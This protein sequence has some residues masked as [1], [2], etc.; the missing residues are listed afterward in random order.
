MLVPEKGEIEI[1]GPL[2]MQTLSP[3]EVQNIFSEIR[4]CYKT[5]TNFLTQNSEG[6]IAVGRYYP[7]RLVKKPF[8]MSHKTVIKEQIVKAARGSENG[9]SQVETGR[10]VTPTL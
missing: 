8:K 2:V 10:S 7:T 4:L 6:E 5:E 9:D 1:K 3:E